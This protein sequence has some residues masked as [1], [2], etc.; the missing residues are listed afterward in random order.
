MVDTLASDRSDQPFGEA[1]LGRRAWDNWLV[2]DAHGPYSGGD[3]S[4]VNARPS[5]GAAGPL[6]P[7]QLSP[8]WCAAANNAMCY[9]TYRVLRRSD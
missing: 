8:Y 9:Q 1:V 5:E 7:L 6:E 2:A 3:G 4:A